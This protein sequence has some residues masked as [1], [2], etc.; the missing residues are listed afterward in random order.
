ME[1]PNAVLLPRAQR[2]AAAEVIKGLPDVTDFPELTWFNSAPC[3]RHAPDP[4]SL[5]PDCGLRLR[6]YQRIGAACLYLGLPRLLGDSVGTGKTAQ[7]AAVL[8]MCKQAGELGYHNRA[9]IVCR[10][11]AV[12]SVWGEQLRRLVPGLDVLIADGE[13]GERLTGYMGQW[14]VAVISAKTLSPARGAKQSREGDVEILLQMPVGIVVGDD[15]D[16]LRNASTQV[17]YAFNRLARGASRVIVAHATSVQKYVTDLWGMLQPVGGRAALGS[18]ARVRARY[19]TRTT[20]VVVTDDP[21]DPTGRTKMRRRIV[22]NTGLTDDPALI[23]E[24]QARVTPLVLRRTADDL[25]DVELPDVQVNPVWVE[26]L[27]AQR[28]RY[29]ELRR[30]VLRRLKDGGEEVTYTEAGAAWLRGWQICSGLAALDEG[31]GTDVS[32]KLDWATAALTGDLAGE[33]AVAF[34]WFKAN[35]AAL[36]RRLAER[37]VGHVLLWGAETNQ[38]VRDTRL[39]RF[40]DDPA[41]QVLIG[42]ATIEASLN[43]QVARHLIAVDTITNAKRMEQLVGRI[44]RQGSPW[45]T[46]FLHHLLAARTQEMGLL[47]M[48]Q[49]EEEL[50]DTIWGE[51]AGLFRL[52]PRQVLRM[53]AYGAPGGREAA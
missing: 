13:P 30:G 4:H 26:L 52:T 27:P 48:L 10:A 6:S 50:S 3:P 49:R 42:T 17:S 5:C 23:R 40:R 39:A 37:G 2:A 25:P 21:E 41:C 18:L 28:T 29:E 51:Q 15:L 45:R 7:V 8:A 43:L 22:T 19:V 47:P 38:R 44:R 14:E 12:R 11:A 35:A 16:E 36:A 9:V 34:V 53:I 33:K 46:V 24:F 31:D 20:R 32:V 1:L